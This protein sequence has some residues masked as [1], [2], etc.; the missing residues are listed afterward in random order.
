[1]QFIVIPRTHTPLFKVGVLLYIECTQYILLPANMAGKR[2]GL[3]SSNSPKKKMKTPP[4]TI[5]LINSLTEED[6]RMDQMKYYGNRE[7]K[8]KAFYYPNKAGNTRIIS[9]L[10]YS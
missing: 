4:L 3:F 1:M 6:F 8:K 5:F 2:W 7:K 9:I 10:E